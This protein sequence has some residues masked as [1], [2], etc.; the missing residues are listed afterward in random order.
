MGLARPV[1]RAKCGPDLGR[2]ARQVAVGIVAVAE[3]VV[4]QEP[5]GGIVALEPEGTG[6]ADVQLVC[7]DAD[8]TVTWELFITEAEFDGR[9]TG[10]RAVQ[11]DRV[12]FAGASD[13]IDLN[14]T[15]S[16]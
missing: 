7:G 8:V 1:L 10:L 3:A 11:P 13:V 6:P 16:D 2:L 9:V 14:L 4:L 15:L 5:V 12:P